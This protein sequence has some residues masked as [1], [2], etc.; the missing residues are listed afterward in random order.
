M[1]RPPCGTGRRNRSFRQV[2][3]SQN[4]GCTRSGATVR[5]GNGTARTAMRERRP[6]GDGMQYSAT[7]RRAGTPRR[8]PGVGHGRRNRDNC[9]RCST[10]RVFTHE[11]SRSFATMLLE[12]TD[13]LCSWSIRFI[14]WSVTP[15]RNAWLSIDAINMDIAPNKSEAKPSLGKSAG[16][17]RSVNPV[18]G[19]AMPVQ[20]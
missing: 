6:T 2:Y 16:T 17:A 18:P 9:A 11:I 14:R 13:E 8:K 19:T 1:I 12:A 10:I 5:P 7:L 4:L 3:N 20:K 15:L